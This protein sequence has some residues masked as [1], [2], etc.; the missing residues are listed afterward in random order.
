MTSTS[1]CGTE[2]FIFEKN[3]F[4]GFGGKELASSGIS[5]YFLI[6]TSNILNGKMQEKKIFYKKV[7]SMFLKYF[8]TEIVLKP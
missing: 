5:G 7:L 8:Q 3:E 4:F 2:L 1:T 6:W